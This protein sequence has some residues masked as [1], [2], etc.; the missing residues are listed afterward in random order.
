VASRDEIVALVRK[1]I[2]ATLSMPPR[3]VVETPRP[4][5][6]HP[7]QRQ[8]Q[9]RQQQ[10]QQQRQQQ[11][12][13]QRTNQSQSAQ[14][15]DQGR[16]GQ[17]DQLARRDGVQHQGQSQQHAPQQQP[18]PPQNGNK[19]VEAVDATRSE[20]AN[21]L[22]SAKAPQQPLPDV[23]VE[24]APK[25]GVEILAMEERDGVRYYTVRDLR[26]KSTVR[27]VTQKSARD[28]WLYAI[29][30]HSNDVYDVSTFDWHIDRAVLSRSQR[31]G[32][33]RYDLALR[34]AAGKVHIFYGVADDAIDSRW[35]ELIVAIMPPVPEPAP[36][37][38]TGAES[39]PAP[40]PTPADILE[41]ETPTAAEIT[42]VAESRPEGDNTSISESES[43]R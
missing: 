26:N 9:Q 20:Q 32:K 12:Q 8:Q 34:D 13:Q 38:A 10:G 7:Q 5:Q 24:G 6:Q 4:T 19:P 11:G 28:L 40:I 35:K 17:K 30:Q 39:A 43:S 27:N 42:P 3:P 25:S 23:Q 18:Q 1:T 37:E 22:E 31:A 33:V 29:M 41:P 14:Q 2:E 16:H 15:R 36:A 21:A